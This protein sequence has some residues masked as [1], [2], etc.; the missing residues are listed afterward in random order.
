MADR[1]GNDTTLKARL[2]GLSGDA[3]RVL[4]HGMMRPCT[5][6]RVRQ[7]V[8]AALA[9]PTVTGRVRHEIEG[10]AS[11]LAEDV[12]EPARALTLRFRVTDEEADRIRANAEKAGLTLSDYVRGVALGNLH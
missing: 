7:A 5:D 1:P 6:A 9:D 11:D 10:M 8:A 4:G 3:A 2:A 12:V